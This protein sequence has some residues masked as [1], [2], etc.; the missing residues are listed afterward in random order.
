M[1]V[2]RF[3]LG[4][5]NSFNHNMLKRSRSA[6]PVF[7]I[8]HDKRAPVAQEGLVTTNEV[9][10]HTPKYLRS[11][12]S[13]SPPGSSAPTNV[14]ELTTS[15]QCNLPPHAPLTLESAAV[16]DVHYTQEHTN[17][18]SECNANLPSA[19]LLELHIAERH[20]PLIAG[21]REKEE[22]TVCRL[23]LSLSRICY[24]H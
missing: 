3:I 4:T 9:M 24:R 17:R 21:L 19:W 22:K 2:L 13:P 8:H 16:F 6:S 23:H 11:S 15:M 20:D 7:Q 1:T 5:D 14:N 10:A 18:C 12:N